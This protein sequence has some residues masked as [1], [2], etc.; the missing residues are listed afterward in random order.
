MPNIS[1]TSH[2][3]NIYK[4][5]K[6]QFIAVTKIIEKDD[7][8][9]IKRTITWFDVRQNR[10]R[11]RTELQ[12]FDCDNICDENTDRDQYDNEFKYYS[13]ALSADIASL[14]TNDN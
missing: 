8:V 13:N 4:S 3:F 14:I 9:M 1:Y 11:K 5:P 10:Y 6:K 7:K 12:T 2:K